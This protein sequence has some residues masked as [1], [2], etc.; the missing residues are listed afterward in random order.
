MNLLWPA[1]QALAI[2]AVARAWMPGTP[3]VAMTRGWV[4]AMAGGC[5]WAFVALYRMRAS[6]PG[7]GASA[8]ARPTDVPA[9]AAMAWPLWLHGI[10]IAA[11]AWADHVALAAVHGPAEAAVYGPVVALAPMY[12]LALVALNGP[13]APMLAAHHAAGDHDALHVLFRAAARWASLLSALPVLVTLVAPDALLRGWPD[14]A[15][16]QAQAALQVAAVAQWIGVACGSV[17]YLLA[18][19]GHARA[20]WFGVAPALAASFVGSWLLIPPLGALGASLANGG[21]LVAANLVGAWVVWRRL[22]ISAFD[23]A[24]VRACGA[25]AVPALVGVGAA[26]VPVTGWA[27]LVLVC[28]AVGLAWLPAAWF[29]GLDTEERTAIRRRLGRAS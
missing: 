4:A 22:R 11:Y 21:A 24:F 12:G 18:M 27:R 9:M 16:P 26:R 23:G 29:G 2:L 6:V 14:L 10:V 3:L 7:A 19:T 25:M 13:L 17:N 1:S 20:V 8:S 15:T 28:M 5:V